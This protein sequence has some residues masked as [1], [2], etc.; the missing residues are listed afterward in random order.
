MS[1]QD[2]RRVWRLART[3]LLK[4]RG[5]CSCTKTHLHIYTHT[6]YI[7]LKVGQSLIVREV[8]KSL[9]L[10]S[11]HMSNCLWQDT[12]NQMWGQRKVFR[13]LLLQYRSSWIQGLNKFRAN[14][15]NMAFFL[16]VTS[17]LQRH[18]YCLTFWSWGTCRRQTKKGHLTMHNRPV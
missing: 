13:L 11:V 15:T 2:I 8:V 12:R 10:P 1:T 16:A 3:S 9:N 17:A 5:L 4:L 6:F 7:T 18:F 14:K